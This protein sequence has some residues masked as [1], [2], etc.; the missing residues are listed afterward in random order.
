[1]SSEPLR[2]KDLVPVHFTLDSEKH[3]KGSGSTGRIICAVTRRE[4]SC[5]PSVLLAKSGQV[6]V[7]VCDTA[8]VAL[9]SVIVAVHSAWCY[10]SS[11][12]CMLQCTHM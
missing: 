9:H 8:A 3:S 1:M 2:T 10:A 11:A 5:Q 4:I 7:T 6:C 12:C